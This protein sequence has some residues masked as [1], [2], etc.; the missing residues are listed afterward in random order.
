MGSSGNVS[1]G[2]FTLGVS[3]SAEDSILSNSGG[4]DCWAWSGNVLSFLE[5]G[6]ADDVDVE[7]VGVHDVILRA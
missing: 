4:N 6:S 5:V 7:V 1:D 3:I 2:D